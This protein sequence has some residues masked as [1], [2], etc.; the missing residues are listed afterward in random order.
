MENYSADIGEK[1]LAKMEELMLL[2]EKIKREKKDAK[3]CSP[4]PSS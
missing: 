2:L 3:E 4:A 1:A